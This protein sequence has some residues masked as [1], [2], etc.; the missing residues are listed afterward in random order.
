MDISPFFVALRH[1]KCTISQIT[2]MSA[3]FLVSAVVALC[4]HHGEMSAIVAWWQLI[5][6]NRL[7]RSDDFNW[8]QDGGCGQRISKWRIWSADF[9]MADLVSWFQKANLVSCLQK[10]NLFSWFQNGW[11]GQLILKWQMWSADFKMATIVSTRA[12]NSGRYRH[13]PSR[14][15]SLNKKMLKSRKKM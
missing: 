10:A 1:N 13:S 14:L 4:F 6:P 7:T 5:S 8:F 2:D 9:K 11:V 12:G 3:V 15:W